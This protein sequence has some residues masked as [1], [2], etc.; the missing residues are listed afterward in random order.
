MNTIFLFAEGKKEERRAKGIVR[1]EGRR[2]RL[3]CGCLSFLLKFCENDKTLHP[4]A[5][6]VAVARICLNLLHFRQ[7]DKVF[8]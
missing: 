8:N 2:Q 3:P 1:K 5:V 6:A 7:L 4:V